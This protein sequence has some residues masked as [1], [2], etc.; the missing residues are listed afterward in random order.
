MR[1]A[2]VKLLQ[3]LQRT[4]VDSLYCDCSGQFLC[5]FSDE[6]LLMPVPTQAYAC[7][8]VLTKLD[9]IKLMPSTIVYPIALTG[10]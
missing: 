7:K 9:S 2:Q 5:T 1:H 3:R 10:I 4:T 6:V 8:L